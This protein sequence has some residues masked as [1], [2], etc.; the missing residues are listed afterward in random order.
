MSTARTKIAAMVPLALALFTGCDAAPPADGAGDEPAVATTEPALPPGLTRDNPLFAG[1]ERASAPGGVETVTSAISQE[2]PTVT[3]GGGGGAP[4]ALKASEY[5]R[6]IHVRMSCAKY[7]DSLEVWWRDQNN[8]VQYS[9]R[10]GG[11]GGGTSVDL[12]LGE[13]ETIVAAEGRHGKFVDRLGLT[14]SWGRTVTCVHVDT[15]TGGLF[16]RPRGGELNVGGAP[17]TQPQIDGKSIHGFFGRAG[18]TLDQIG[19]YFYRN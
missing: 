13:G 12:A 15:G 2:T 18:K 10:I 7:M 6:L 8:Q 17:F 11:T 1:G 4:F 19:F 9:G 14:T 16:P 3:Y 5:W